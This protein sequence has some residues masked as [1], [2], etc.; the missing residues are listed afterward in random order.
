VLCESGPAR[1]VSLLRPDLLQLL[2]SKAF[3]P[4]GIRMQLLDLEGNPTDKG[5]DGQ[6]IFFAYIMIPLHRSP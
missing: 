3:C 5:N 1:K 4:D 6:G 2:S